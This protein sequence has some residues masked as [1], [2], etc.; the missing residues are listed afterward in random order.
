MQVLVLTKGTFQCSTWSE[1]LP[2]LLRKFHLCVMGIY[3]HVS[4]HYHGNILAKQVIHEEDLLFEHDMLSPTTIIRVARILLLC[5]ICV[6][7]PT[8]LIELVK[9]LERKIGKTNT[10]LSDLHWLTSHKPFDEFRGHILS[11]WM[12]P[13]LLV[14]GSSS[15]KSRSLL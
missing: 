15:V 11:Q 14:L 10:V 12:I 7:A 2:I 13:Y 6:K 3:R 5:R 8:K 4:G 1:L 9:C